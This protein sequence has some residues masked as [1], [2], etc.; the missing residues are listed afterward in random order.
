M[1][2]RAVMR[3]PNADRVRQGRGGRAQAAGRVY[4]I[5]GAEA[6]S[7][8]NLIISTCLLYGKSCCVLFDSRATHSFISKACVEKLGLIE[9]EMQFDL[10]V[11][12]PAAGEVRTST[13]CIRCP[14]EVEER[15]FK[16]NLIFLPLQGLEVIL[17]TDWLAAN[18][19]L[20]DCGEKRLVFPDGEEEF[21]VTIGQLR[22]HI[23][24]G[25]G[26]F[27]VLSYLE[28][29]ED[30]YYGHSVQGEQTDNC[31]II[32]E[33][34]DVFPNEVPRLPP[35]REVEFSIDLVLGVGPISIAPYKMSSAELTELKGQIEDLMDKQFI[36]S[37]ASPWGA[38]ILLVKKKDGSSRLCID[39]K[40]LNKLTI[41]NKY[42]LPR[43]DDLLDQLHGAVI[44][45]KIDL[46]SR[47]HQIRVKEGDV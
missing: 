4:A 42:P 5:T 23:M 12:S 47:Y 3:P 16:V 17:G 10:V 9:S 21:S 40:Q 14:T 32:S 34:M 11:S 44:F 18:H 38:P 20:I 28:A 26:C 25:V 43:I 46:R 29:V 37:S 8:G 22:E 6:A 35:P 33:F 30:K 45:S 2:R 36:R 1:G 24:E 31:S 41:K 19:I 27:L 7:S 13:M 39:Y 15:R